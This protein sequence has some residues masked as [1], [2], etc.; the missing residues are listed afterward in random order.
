MEKFNYV[1]AKKWSSDTNSLC[2]YAYGA[3]VFYGDIEDAKESLDFIRDRIGVN[4]DDY[5][6]YKIENMPLEL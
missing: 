5:Q 4:P 1:I 3:T 2:C 6:I